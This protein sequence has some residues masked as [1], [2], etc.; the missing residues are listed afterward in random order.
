MTETS[1][2]RGYP[3][4][5]WILWFDDDAEIAAAR[6]QWQMIVREMFECD[7]ITEANV[8]LIA[9]LVVTQILYDRS[10]REV[11]SK[12]AVLSPKKSSSRAIARVSPHFTAMVK[13]SSEA[14]AL[15]NELGL[16]PSSRGRVTKA[17]R[18]A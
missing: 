11:A 6:Q 12:G 14:L 10:A 16:T 18:R 9:K 4:P 17:F 8:P 2:F 3:T 13:L 5:D 7:T 15:E 1:I